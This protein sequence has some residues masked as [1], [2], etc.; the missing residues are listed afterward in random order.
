[1][2]LFRRKKTK[3][4][5]LSDKNLD[6]F[7][8]KVFED[9]TI[10]SLD[11]SNNHI[12]EI[13][14]NIGELTKLKYLHL[15]NNDIHQLHNGIL[16]VHSLKCLFLK[17][18]PM[19]NLPNFIK[20]NAH[21]N[22]S[23]DSGYHHYYP[24]VE[25]NGDNKE[26]QKEIGGEVDG[27]I[28]N[29]TS[30]D[31]CTEVPKVTDQNLTYPRHKERKGKIIN[32]C[33]LFVDIRESVLKNNIH[34]APTLAKMYSSFIYGVLRIAKEYNGHVRNIIGDRVMVVFDENDCCNNAI[35]CA[36]SIL[37]FCRKEMGKTIPKDCF[38]CGVG[39][40]YGTMNVI[41]VGLTDRSDEHDEYQN[42]V[43]IGEPANLASRLTDM[44]G[45]SNIPSIV[46]SHDVYKRLS[47]NPLKR[48]FE[49]V[50][51]K[52]FKDIDFGVRGCNLLIK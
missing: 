3:K 9:K 10:T 52:K 42:L 45:K 37:F 30:F 32:T 49:I 4:L 5:D 43:W 27:I 31:S 28:K 14:A 33:V 40:H 1:M 51:K 21:F 22:I 18:N 34:R 26:L 29:N 41:K 13:P 8:A 24:D 20:E 12:K 44:A 46:I 25:I 39:I 48:N 17:G 50:D 47:I 36:G 19:K 7:P 15:E 6:V 35:K 16:K 11:L 38:D 23:M 2:I